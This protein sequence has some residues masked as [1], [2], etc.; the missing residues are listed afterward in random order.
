LVCAGTTFV[1]CSLNNCKNINKTFFFHKAYATLLT[2]MVNIKI[3]KIDKSTLFKVELQVGNFTF[4]L[5]FCTFVQQA[6][7][8]QNYF[9]QKKV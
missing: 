8:K 2:K 7:K 3:V 1:E 6:R 4:S 5:I 9:R